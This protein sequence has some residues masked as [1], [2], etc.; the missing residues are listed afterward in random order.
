[1]TERQN[2]VR[3]CVH[4]HYFPRIDRVQIS[5]AIISGSG[6]DVMTYCRYKSIAIVKWKLFWFLFYF[7]T[8]FS[9]IKFQ[10][11]FCS[12]FYCLFIYFFWTFKNFLSQTI[13]S[14]IKSSRY[15]IMALEKNVFFL[16]IFL[17]SF[18]H[19]LVVFALFHRHLKL[20]YFTDML[21][22]SF[23]SIS[24][25]RVKDFFVFFISS[26]RPYLRVFTHIPLIKRS[27]LTRIG[28]F[29]G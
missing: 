27:S 28:Q 23:Y 9:Q 1:M 17:F 16:K 11:T 15:F 6:Y 14:L 4:A 22:F 8:L 26:F 21:N 24:A 7:L 5:L 19:S 10:K 13:F 2:E 29:I 20:I 18:F 25:R 3:K 12:P